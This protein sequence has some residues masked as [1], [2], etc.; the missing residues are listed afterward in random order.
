MSDFQEWYDCFYTENE[1]APEELSHN[2]LGTI[3][4]AHQQDKIDQLTKENERLRESK[5]YICAGASG[6]QPINECCGG[7]S[8][9][10]EMQMVHSIDQL[11]KENE[12]FGVKLKTYENALRGYEDLHRLLRGKS[13]GLGQ[14]Y[15]DVAVNYIEKLECSNT[16]QKCGCTEFLCGHNKRTY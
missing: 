8:G 16:C 1:I 11:T 7:C 4:W 3:I 2:S 13:L 9:C 14:H 5:S 10:I 6:R 12:E 15:G